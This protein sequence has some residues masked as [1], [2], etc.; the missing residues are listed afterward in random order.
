MSESWR[1]CWRQW[2]AEIR[3]RSGKSVLEKWWS[4][5]R[6]HKSILKKKA[7][8]LG[9][10]LDISDSVRSEIEERMTKI[11]RAH[12]KLTNNVWKSRLLIWRVLES[13]S[14]V[15][16]CKTCTISVQTRYKKSYYNNSDSWFFWKLRFVLNEWESAEIHFRRLLQQSYPRVESLPTKL[17]SW[18]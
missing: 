11:K 14:E 2:D 5:K 13:Q 3:A 7:T 17:D 10:Y 18:S 1:S 15:L 16:L 9:V 6:G 12:A 8:Y 4:T